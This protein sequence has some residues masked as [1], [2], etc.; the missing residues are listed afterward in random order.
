MSL[1]S[2]VHD[3]FGKDI[4]EHPIFYNNDV[5][6]RFE[7]ENPKQSYSESVNQSV[8]RAADLFSH[9]FADSESMVIVFQRFTRNF[10]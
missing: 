10:I 3:I 6:L 8:H 9:L 4:F 5:S 1:V 2:T 7:L